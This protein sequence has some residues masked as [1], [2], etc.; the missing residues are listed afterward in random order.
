MWEINVTSV[1][2]SGNLN[3]NCLL[4]VCFCA[5]RRVLLLQDDALIMADVKRPRD[6]LLNAIKRAADVSYVPTSSLCHCNQ[7][8][9]YSNAGV[10]ATNQYCYS[11]A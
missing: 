5:D 8:T 6:L 10:V 11:L 2:A 3:F 4:C 1:I 9:A 7:T